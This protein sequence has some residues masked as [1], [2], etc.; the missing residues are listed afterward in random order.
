[1]GFMSGELPD[2]TLFEIAIGEVVRQPVEASSRGSARAFGEMVSL[3]WAQGK[4]DAALALEGL[5]NKLLAKDRF[6]LCC[7]W[8][9]WLRRVSNFEIEATFGC[10]A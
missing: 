4:E 1:M 9:C 5:W 10:S 2:E 7:G 3:L 8:Q 6:L